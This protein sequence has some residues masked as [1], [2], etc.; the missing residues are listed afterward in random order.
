M[1]GRPYCHIGG[2][3]ETGPK[4]QLRM[5]TGFEGLLRGGSRDVACPGAPS[6]SQE[7]HMPG[8]MGPGVPHVHRAPD[9]RTPLAAAPE[10]MLQSRRASR[11]EVGGDRPGLK[12]LG[13]GL[14]P[15]LGASGTAGGRSRIVRLGGPPSWRAPPRGLAVEVEP[16]KNTNTHHTRTHYKTAGYNMIWS[17]AGRSQLVTP[18]IG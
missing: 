6:R 14:S 11:G 1:A 17:T 2:P 15:R 10:P 4:T 13:S 16:G 12:V 5:E 8:K 3:P 9:L 7:Q 18:Y